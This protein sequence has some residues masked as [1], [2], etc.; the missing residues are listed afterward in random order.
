MCQLPH[1]ALWLALLDLCVMAT[2][3]MLCYAPLVLGVERQTSG[4][5]HRKGQGLAFYGEGGFKAYQTA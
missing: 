4:E 5:P 1:P 2:I 3:A